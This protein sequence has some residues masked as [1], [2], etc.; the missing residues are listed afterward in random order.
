MDENSALI[1]LLIFTLLTVREST[2]PVYWTSFSLPVNS[3]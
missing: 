3:L 1:C 2:F